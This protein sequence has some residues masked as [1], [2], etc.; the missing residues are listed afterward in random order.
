M[1]TSNTDL[2]EL[3]DLSITAVS[4][5]SPG[6]Q[7]IVRDLFRGF[8]WNRIPKGHRTKLGGM[9]FAYATGSGSD[10]LEPLDKT[11]QNQQ[12]YKKK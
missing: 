12:R 6:E 4:D 10:T 11:A 2:Q 3:F 1:I 8:E 9:F 7:F 5:V